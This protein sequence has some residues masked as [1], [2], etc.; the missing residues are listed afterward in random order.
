MDL[1]PIYHKGLLICVIY[2]CDLLVFGHQVI[3]HHISLSLLLYTSWY[4]VVGRHVCLATITHPASTC[5]LAGFLNAVL[6]GDR[7]CVLLSQSAY[8]T[9]SL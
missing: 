2:M 6:A 8:R 1:L 7:A 5:V 4:T 9:T 3:K